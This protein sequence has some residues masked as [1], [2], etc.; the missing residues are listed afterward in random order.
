MSDLRTEQTEE[1]KEQNIVVPCRLRTM[2]IDTKHV[3]HAHVTQ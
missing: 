1:K 3:P 2:M